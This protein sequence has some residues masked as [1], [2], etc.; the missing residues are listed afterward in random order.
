VTETIGLAQARRIA[1][2]AQGFGARRPDAPAGNHLLRV[3][4]RL[5]LH[6]IDSVNVLTRAHYLPAFS[7]LGSYDTGE[8]DRLAWGR[9]ASAGSTNIGRMRHRCCPRHASAAALADGAR[10]SG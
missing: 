7:R 4:D 8:L 10:R 5:Q 6:Q 2:A 1:L 3:I 9:C